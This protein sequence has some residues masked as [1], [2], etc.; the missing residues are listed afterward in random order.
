ME[1]STYD[2]IILGAG[3]AGLTAAGAAAAR[4]RRVLILEKASHP[5]GKLLLSGGG[6]GNVT[7]RSVRATDYVSEG[8]SGFVVPALKHF[9]PDM[10][11]RR[12]AESGIAVEE[13]EHGRIFCVRSAK[14]I[15]DMLLAALPGSRCRLQCNCAIADINFERGFFFVRAEGRLVSAPKLIAATGSA[16]W[17]QC[18]ADDSGLQ[19][20][21]KLGHRIVPARPVLVPFVL[22]P[23]TPFTDLAGISVLV[24]VGC[25]APGAP[26]F[27]EPVLFTHKG[28]SG[29][30]VLQISCYWRKGDALRLDFLPQQ[31]MAALLDRAT[32]K[33]T[34]QSILSN[35]LP[36]RLCRALLPEQ[37][38]TRRAA[39]LSRKDRTL[40]AEAVH[41]YNVIPLRT[42]GLAR[43][44][45]AAGGVDTSEM[46][47]E[48]ME[49]KLVPGLFLCG[50]VLDI[51]GRL[52]GYNL[53][54]AWASGDLAGKTVGGA[55]TL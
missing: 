15:L 44:E 55:G 54:W 8:S 35:F 36:D 26:E 12:L 16:A 42:E 5:A 53:H 33:A 51:T 2:L 25:S 14:D 39:E 31:D 40:T 11:L 27:T 18:G 10:L 37:T 38:A 29:P 49:S 20:L 17:P 9:T 23:D 45:A 34:P 32:G 41:N 13:R 21:R 30:A 48:T 3:P 43:A 52:G 47:S 24:R 19:F 46:E 6:K 22:P 4:G 50:E 7:N 28:L 1:N